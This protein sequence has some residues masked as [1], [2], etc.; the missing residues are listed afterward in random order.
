MNF[1]KAV[2]VTCID[3]RLQ[4]Y[5]NKWTDQNFD[6]FTFDRVAI[7]GSTKNLEFLMT[8]IKKAYDLHRIK[9][10]VLINHEDCGAYGVDSNLK[11]HTEDLN[12]AKQKINQSFPDLKVETYYL[13]LDGTFQIIS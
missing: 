7:G 6:P 9:E 4:P 13:S 3:Y 2:V 11:K 5:I 1:P 8:Q 12:N 10:V